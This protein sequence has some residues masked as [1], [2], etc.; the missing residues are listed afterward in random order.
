LG[1]AT[2]NAVVFRIGLV[3][4]VHGDSDGDGKADPAVYRPS[5]RQWSILYSS[6]NYTTSSGLV[7]WGGASA[8]PAPGDYDGDGKAD[9]AVF[10]PS[11]GEWWMLHSSTGNATNSGPVSWASA[12]MC[13]LTRGHRRPRSTA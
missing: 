8:V 6:T 13:R 4:S 5:T 3:V 11:T 1:G 10:I 7:S 2:G 12:L 9:P